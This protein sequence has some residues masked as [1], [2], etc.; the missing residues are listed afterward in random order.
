MGL[1]LVIWDRGLEGRVLLRGRRWMI[2]FGWSNDNGCIID[3]Y[4]WKNTLRNIET[5]TN[6][7]VF[8]D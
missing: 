4:T 1:R 7:S 5:D 3:A 6:C 8:Q 2:L